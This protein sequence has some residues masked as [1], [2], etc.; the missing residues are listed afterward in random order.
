MRG[1]LTSKKRKKHQR[2]IN[3]VIRDMNNSIKNDTLWLGRFYARQLD[4]WFEEYEDHSGASLY[5]RLRFYDRKTGITR[6]TSYDSVN[7]WRFSGHLFFEMNDFIINDV[8]VWEN[9][10]P[11]HDE[12]IDYRT[13]QN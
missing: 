8:K 10:D 5:I 3:K 11:Y 2:S 6:D 7:V 12:K 4:G 1:W 13:A 9:E